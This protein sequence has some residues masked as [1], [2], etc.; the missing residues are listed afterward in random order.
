MYKL[1]YSNALALIF[2]PTVPSEEQQNAH[3][4]DLI[5]CGRI[6]G[7]KSRFTKAATASSPSSG[8]DISEKEHPGSE[9]LIIVAPKV[10]APP[11]DMGCCHCA[12]AMPYA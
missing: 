5:L 8:T 12:S 4:F 7:G 3:N 6:F 11:I 1:I 10:S 2:I 9:R